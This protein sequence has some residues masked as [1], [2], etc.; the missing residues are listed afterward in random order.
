MG[1]ARVALM[2]FSPQISP[3]ERFALR[4]GSKDTG[5]LLLSWPLLIACR[6]VTRLAGEPWS[7]SSLTGSSRNCSL[8]SAHRGR[9]GKSMGEDFGA[10]ITFGLERILM[11]IAPSS[12]PPEEGRVHR[13]SCAHAI[14]A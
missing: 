12:L 14:R 6:K 10:G 7:E 1:H 5:F 9:D 13:A 3:P 11:G 2:A 4:D 8:Q